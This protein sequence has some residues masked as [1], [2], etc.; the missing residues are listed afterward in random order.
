MSGEC[1]NDAYKHGSLNIKGDQ[2]I[3]F[4]K[5]EKKTKFYVMNI[6]INRNNSDLHYHLK[7]P[8]TISK[9]AYRE[10]GPENRRNCLTFHALF[11]KYMD[12]VVILQALMRL[13]E[14]AGLERSDE[15]FWAYP[16][17]YGIQSCRLVPEIEFS[18]TFFHPKENTSI[19]SCVGDNI[20]TALSA[21]GAYLKSDR[22]FTLNALSQHSND[23]PSVIMDH[24]GKK[25]AIIMTLSEQLGMAIAE[26]KAAQD[27][28][29]GLGKRLETMRADHES[30]RRAWETKILRYE[31]TAQIKGWKLQSSDSNDEEEEKIGEIEGERPVKIINE[32]KKRGT[33]KEAS[34]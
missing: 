31:V 33:T 1:N 20:S 24:L 11:S 8:G 25:D 34:K 30:E 10:L 21:T 18:Q 4:K 22:S 9:R 3:F 29:E 13:S 14:L 7:Y 28:V 19:K 16:T 26:K 5:G 32:G 17:D 2:P 12:D 15:G 23:W 6:Y 27:A